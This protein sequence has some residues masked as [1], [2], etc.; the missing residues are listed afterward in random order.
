MMS[1]DWPRINAWCVTDAKSRRPSTDLV[2]RFKF[3]GATGA[4]YFLWVV[5]ESVP[6]H[7]EWMATHQVRRPRG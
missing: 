4:Y 1:I 3:L 2:R 7:E 5:G 6:P